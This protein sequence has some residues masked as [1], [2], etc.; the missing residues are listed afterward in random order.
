MYEKIRKETKPRKG[1]PMVVWIALCLVILGGIVGLIG[2]AG[3]YVVGFRYFVGDLSNSTHYAYE[4]QS[5]TVQSE[6]EEYAILPEN[7]Y[8]IYTR[9]TSA[10]SGRLGKAPAA[11]PEMVLDYGDG[12]YMELWMVELVNS[13]N[14]RAYGLFINYVNQK[15]RSYS[16]DTDKLTLSLLPLEKEENI[17]Q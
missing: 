4:N 14:G 7:I 8:H 6:G 3:G 9:I 2:W 1:F 17:V 15:G 10:G 16:Y 5:L 12:S 11:P 13:S